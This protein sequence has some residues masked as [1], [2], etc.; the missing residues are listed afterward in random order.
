MLRFNRVCLV[1][2]KM[3]EFTAKINLLRVEKDNSSTNYFIWRF[4]VLCEYW[5][6]SFCEPIFHLVLACFLWPSVR[7]ASEFLRFL[8]DWYIVMSCVCYWLQDVGLGHEFDAYQYRNNQK[9][10]RNKG[11]SRER[12]IHSRKLKKTMYCAFHS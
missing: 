7:C 8:E 11:N 3:L 9:Y 2:G 10:Q 5:F 6:L 4:P 1:G 12:R